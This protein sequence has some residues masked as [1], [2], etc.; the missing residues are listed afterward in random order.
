MKHILVIDDRRLDW[1]QMALGI[2][3]VNARISIFTLEESRKVLDRGDVD[4]IILG[5][6]SHQLLAAPDRDIPV[7][8]ISEEIPRG[9]TV[10]AR[11]GRS[12]VRLGWP[13]SRKT[14]TELT[15][16][17]L[18]VPERRPFRTPVLIG[19]GKGNVSFR[20]NSED[21]SLGGMSFTTAGNLEP[22]Q[23]I[24]VSFGGHEERHGL[25]LEADVVRRHLLQDPD[26]VLYGAR[27]R[28]LTKEEQHALE[29]FVWRI[30]K[31]GQP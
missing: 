9:E 28:T 8:I 1:S 19:V 2:Q 10:R 24:T 5:E 22:R 12:A 6:E 16:R 17:I 3:D 23:G 25:R 29:R 15:S 7:L 27:F 30:P 21:F 11:G 14:F 31:R 20:G 18:A 4:L 13:V 26:S